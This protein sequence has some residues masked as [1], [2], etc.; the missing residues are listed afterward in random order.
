MRWVGHVTCVHSEFSRDAWRIELPG[1][2]RCRWENTIKINLKAAGWY[3]LD[4][5]SGPN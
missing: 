3:G 2:L 1:S 5:S 4:S